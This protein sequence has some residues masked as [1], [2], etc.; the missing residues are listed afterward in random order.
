MATNLI[1]RGRIFNVTVP[2][3][4]VSGDPVMIGPLSGVLQDDRVAATGRANVEFSRDLVVYD[5]S[6]QAV[7]DAG[8][9]TVAVGDVLNYFATDV[10][11]LS[12]RTHGVQYGVAFEAIAAAGATDTI[13]VALFDE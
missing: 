6:V 8:N 7:N 1:N 3:G 9:T 5:L 4:L 10:P 13:N 2:A 12:L 11:P